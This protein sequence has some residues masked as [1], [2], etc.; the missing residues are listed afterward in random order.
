MRFEN[1][2][3]AELGLLLYALAPSEEYHHKLGLGKPLGL[4]SVKIE[5][6]AVFEIDRIKRYTAAGLRMA[7]YTSAKLAPG[8]RQVQWP[9]RY[10][11]LREKAE[12]SADLLALRDKVLTD[13]LVTSATHA[14]IRALGDFAKAP[15]SAS[16]HTPTIAEQ[17]D[18][19][20][21]TYRWFVEN[22]ANHNALMPATDGLK[23]LP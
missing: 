19:E 12:E 8:E 11:D 6:A 5:V 21:D 17:K 7:R 23:P 16:I 4:G 3:D 15:A 1:L 18:P 2:A 10:A 20:V 22:E 13:R 9:T 14:A